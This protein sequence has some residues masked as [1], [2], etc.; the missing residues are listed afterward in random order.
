MAAETGMPKSRRVPTH[1]RATLRSGVWR[2]T[3]DGAWYGDYLQR[4]PAIEAAHLSALR[5]VAGGGSAEVRVIADGADVQ[6]ARN[7]SHFPAVEAPR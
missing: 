1:L 2:V 3:E 5:I 6:P 4:G 7:Y